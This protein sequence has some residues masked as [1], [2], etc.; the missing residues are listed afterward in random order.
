MSQIKPYLFRVKVPRLGCLMY[1]IRV[2]ESRLIVTQAIGSLS[3]T[4]QMHPQMRQDLRAD[5]G[6]ILV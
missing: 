2:T 5:S 1:S 4:L 3:Q 6:D